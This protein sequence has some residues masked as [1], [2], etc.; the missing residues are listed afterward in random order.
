MTEGITYDLH[1]SEATE[2]RSSPLLSEHRDAGAKVTE[3]GG[4]LVPLSYPSGIIAEHLAC[5]NDAAVFDVSHLGTVL[6][7]GRDLQERIQV[8]LSNDLRKIQPGRTQYSHLLD[9]SDGSVLDDVIIWWISPEVAHVMPNATNTERVCKALGGTDITNQRAVL[10]VQGPHA[11]DKLAKLSPQAAAVPHN[12]V[13]EFEWHGVTAIAS[14][15]GYTGEDGVECA[16]ASSVCREFWRALLD[17]GVTPAGLGARDTLRLE[18]G[19]PLY[20]HELGPGITPLQAGLDW[21]IGWEKGYFMGR[22]ALELERERGVNRHLRG[23]LCEGRRPAREGFAVLLDGTEVGVVTS[24]NYSPMLERGIALA[25][26]GNSVNLGD[27]VKL[28]MDKKVVMG[29]I[30]D[31]PFYRAKR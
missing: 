6:L 28:V 12:H 1:R 23:I 14:G 10:A 11:R 25:L 29:T 19:L 16:I 13:K 5:R 22:R 24:G 20:G 9:D 27:K 30:V 26:C 8:T 2:L 7:T 15:T 4:F 18:A 17:V 3:F 31:T 21:V